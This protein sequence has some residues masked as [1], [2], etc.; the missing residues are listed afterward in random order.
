M[1]CNV[2]GLP[3]RP[4]APVDSDDIA[5]AIRNAT[6]NRP[7]AAGWVGAPKARSRQH[8]VTGR[9]RPSAQPSR[10]LACGVPTRPTNLPTTVTPFRTPDGL[11]LRFVALRGVSSFRSKKSSR[12]CSARSLRPSTRS[13]FTAGYGSH[14]PAHTHTNLS[15][16]DPGR[17]TEP[18]RVRRRPSPGRGTSGCS[19]PP[20]QLA[21]RGCPS[22]HAPDHLGADEREALDR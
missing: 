13:T 12:A 5:Q 18:S 11:C 16:V 20:E 22:G 2:I 6:R 3:N 21:R 7:F 19:S 8:A 17:F 4:S 14:R 1:S 9:G 10:G 15:P